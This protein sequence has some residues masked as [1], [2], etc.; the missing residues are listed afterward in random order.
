MYLFNDVFRSTENRFNTGGGVGLI[1]QYKPFHTIL[2]MKPYPCKGFKDRIFP[3]IWGI[4]HKCWD[5]WENE[6]RMESIS[7]G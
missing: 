3:Q 7:K 4:F 1:P 6:L 2:K 5:L